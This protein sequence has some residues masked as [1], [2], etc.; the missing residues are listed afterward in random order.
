[1]GGSN[2]F[3][4][5]PNPTGWIDP[6]GLSGSNLVRYKPNKVTP[7]AGSRQG[8][9][10]KAWALEKELVETTGGGTRNWSPSEIDTIK[11]TPIGSK[12]GQLSSV[13]SNKGYTGHHINSVK[14]NGTLGQAWKGDPRNII[15]LENHKHPNSSSRPNAYNEH[16]HS[17]QGHR[18]S[19]GNVSRGRLIDRAEMIRQAGRKKPCV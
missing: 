6:F 12:S 9:I 4:Y 13:M 16:F 7:T 3:Q 8:A 1:M 11:N 17:M 15:F 10:D 19:T 14:N 18:G 2:V 5:A